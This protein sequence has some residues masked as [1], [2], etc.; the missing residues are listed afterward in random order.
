M[1]KIIKTPNKR[2]IVKE[3]ALLTE[4]I[5]TTQEV[6]KLRELSPTEKVHFEYEV[7][8]SHLYN[9]SKIEGSKLNE[10]RLD[11]AIHA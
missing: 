2:T 3:D 9:S 8:K 10:Y 11:K 7:D 5:T 4:F 1:K 6:Q